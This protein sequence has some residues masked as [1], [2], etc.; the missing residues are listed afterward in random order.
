MP[1]PIRLN[2]KRLAGMSLVEVMVA[3]VI[4][5][6]GVLV[7]MQILT[8]TEEQKRTTTSGNDAMNEG[9]LGL[10]T[11]QTDL[12]M[13]GYGITDRKLM[14]CALTLRAG[15]VLNNLGPVLIN[16]SVITG[17]DANTDTLLVFYGLTTGTPQ[18]DNIVAAGNKVQTPVVFAANDWVVPAYASTP[19]PCNLLLEQV[20]TVDVPSKVATLKSG[21]ALDGYITGS[22]P[23]VLFN[24]GQSY[25]AVGYAI[26]GGNLT[27]CDFSSAGTNCT[28]ASSWVAIANDMVSLRA[29]YGRDVRLDA[30]LPVVKPPAVVNAIVSVYDQTT[31]TTACGWSRATAVRL[32]LV[33]RSTQVEKD[34]VTTAVP[35][36]EGSYDTA[37]NP[38][39]AIALPGADWQ[40]YRYKVFQTTVPLRNLTWMGVLTGC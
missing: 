31:P 8:V 11:M 2:R 33:A 15:V 32:A 14:G 13:A 19:S 4:G 20:S 35:V 40:N 6:F 16:P 39:A 1:H 17:Q 26:R 22:G 38:A 18:G 23:G 36:W 10:Y 28:L 37:G 21:N 25:R 27:M 12:R 7:M 29:Q 30:A 5:M 34:A 3:L 9:V 24:L